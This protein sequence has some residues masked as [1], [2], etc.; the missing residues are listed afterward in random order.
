MRQDVIT[1]ETIERP[2]WEDIQLLIGRDLLEVLDRAAEETGVEIR[3]VGGAV[4]DLIIDRPTTDLDFVLEGDCERVAD[5]IS[6]LLGRGSQATIFRNFRTAQVKYRGRELE[7]VGARRESYTEESRKPEVSEGTFAED[8]AR[9][10]FTINVLSVTVT[11]PEAGTLHDPFEGLR[12]LSMGIIRTPL[13]PDIT[14][15]DDPLR[16]MRAVRFATQ[17]HFTI[18]PDM[19]A[20]I[21]RNADRLR[22]VSADRIEGEFMKIMAC[23]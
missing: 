7:F 17:L 22:I 16:M 5:R 14:F 12:D 9:R 20:A 6:E 21:R 23:R 19:L 13:D 15:S 11:G 18:P 8:E 4:R 1:R 2:L 10:D 3:L